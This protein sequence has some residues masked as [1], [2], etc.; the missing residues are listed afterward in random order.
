[1]AKAKKAKGKW[2][3][4]K[5]IVVVISAVILIAGATVGGVYLTGGFDERHINPESIA[6]VLDENLY[7]SEHEQFEVT[8][9]FSLTISTPT[10]DVTHKD[11]NLS[12][13]S[14]VSV[15]HD[16]I[17]KTLSDGII[18]VPETVQIGTPFTVK[19]NKKLTQMSGEQIVE[20]VTGGISKLRA[21]STANDQISA[22]E[23]QIAV[24]VPVHSIQVELFDAVSNSINEITS[25]E[26]FTAQTHFFPVGSNYFYS[27]DKNAA[28]EEK[29]EKLAYYTV[30][31]AGNI[32]FVYSDDGVSFEAGERLRDNNTSSI[33][34]YTFRSADKQT[35]V[36][37]NFS[38]YSGS[39]L[40]STVL[41]YLANN[42]ETVC[43]TN[44][45]SPT[46][47][48]V[49][50]ATIGY[51]R[52]EQAGFVFNLINNA[53]YRIT[54]N[55]DELADNYLGATIGGTTTGS[56]LKSMLKNIAIA[57]EEEIA[58]DTWR[59]ITTDKL[60]VNG[61]GSVEIDG[62]TYY[63]PNT[64][65]SD[66][67]SAYFDLTAKQTLNLRMT[68]VLLQTE[69]IDEAGYTVYSVYQPDKAT[70][71]ISVKSQERQEGEISWSKEDP[72]NI[73]LGYNGSEI[74][75]KTFIFGEGENAQGVV[76]AS[77][78][79]QSKVYFAYFG[80]NDEE[81]A[82]TI[83]NN[84][85]GEGGY[86]HQGLYNLG[87]TQP[88]YLFP[89]EGGELTVRATQNFQVFVAT[90]KTNRVGS[91]EVF[92]Y[93]TNGLYT[94][95]K[96]APQSLNVYVA[97]SLYQGSV[98][99]T[100]NA[101]VEGYNNQVMTDNYYL[102]AGSDRVTRI[103]LRFEINAD[104]ASV[105]AEKLVN[106][107]VL[108]L[109]N[110][111]GADIT[112]YFSIEYPT[113]LVEDNDG[114][115]ARFYADFTLTVRST[116]NVT[117]EVLLK[118]AKLTETGSKLEWERDVVT[119]T[120]DN[121]SKLIYIYMPTVQDITI[122][123]DT[124]DLTKTI[125]VSQEL[126]ATSGDFNTNIIYYT[127]ADTDTP[128]GTF[129]STEQLIQNL[130]VVVTD[131]HFNAFV[132]NDSW[133][134]ATTNSTVVTVGGK[135]FTFR[136]AD[137]ATADIYATCGQKD[138]ARIKFQVTS[139]GIIAVEYDNQKVIGG[140]S[141]WQRSAS[142]ASV[143][144]N[145]YASK[146]GSI[147][148]K[149]I[150]KLYT[151][152]D[153]DDQVDITSQFKKFVVKFDEVKLTQLGDLVVPLF[154]T[155]GMLTVYANEYN[156]ENQLIG[157]KAVEFAKNDAATI[158]STL[159]GKEIVSLA[160]KYDFANEDRELGFVISDASKSG[161][162]AISLSLNLLTNAATTNTQA[163]VEVY[164]S[165]GSEVVG[166]VIFN[167]NPDKR[168]SI[169][170][171]IE[172]F[173]GK[174]IATNGNQTNKNING[175]NV[176][177]NE[178]EIVDASTT[179]NVVGEIDENGKIVF[180]DFWDAETKYYRLILNLE[181]FSNRYALYLQPE[182]TVHRNI[183]VVYKSYS[184]EDVDN[185]VVTADKLGQQKT[186]K[187]LG[188]TNAIRDY[189]EIARIEG[190]QPFNFE[191]GILPSLEPVEDNPVLTLIG[192]GFN[193]GLAS[194]EGTISTNSQNIPF[195]NYHNKNQ[196]S[197][198]AFKLGGTTIDTIGL[199]YELGIE[200]E[201]VAVNLYRENA[202]TKEIT[203]R[204][205]TEKIGDRTYI[206][207]QRGTYKVNGKIST[208]P[209]GQSNIYDFDIYQ[210]ITMGGQYYSNTFYN[211]MPGAETGE[212]VV[213]FNTPQLSA[214]QGLTEADEKDIILIFSSNG[215]RQAV[216]IMPL[217][218][219][220]I[221][222]DFVNYVE[223]EEVSTDSE[224]RGTNIVNTHD[225]FNTLENALLEPSKLFEKGVYQEVRA[226]ERIKIASK[227][228]LGQVPSLDNIGFVTLDDEGAPR[229]T[230]SI[231]PTMVTPTEAIPSGQDR[232][233][234]PEL[235]KN[236]YD[237]ENGDIE[238]QLNH[239]SDTIQTAYVAIK[240]VVSNG[241]W[242]LPFYYLLKVTPNAKVNEPCY[243]FDS[244]AQKAGKENITGVVNEIIGGVSGINLN[245]PWGDA[246]LN[247]GKTRFSVTID[248]K[249][250]SN[251]PSV[252]RVV[253]V[254]VG[255]GDPLTTEEEYKDYIDV[256]LLNGVM[257]VTPKTTAAIRLIIKRVYNGGLG[258][259]QLSV[260]GGE[261]QYIFDI[262]ASAD[263]YLLYED[264]ATDKLS[265]V[266]VSPLNRNEAI[267]T[268]KSKA[269]TE[270]TI[271]VKLINNT[272]TLG[273]VGTEVPG[274]LSYAFFD[275]KMQPIENSAAGI[276]DSITYDNMTFDLKVTRSE[277]VS[278]DK[279]V[280]VLF[281]TEYGL[282]GQLNIIVEASAQA[283]YTQQ[284]KAVHSGNYNLSD[285]ARISI[286]EVEETDYTV[287]KA[288]QI[289]EEG[290]DAAQRLFVFDK[291][292][293]K[294]FKF[295]PAIRDEKVRIEIEIEFNDAEV[296]AVD[297]GTPVPAA[298]RT[299]A[300]TLELD[301]KKDIVQR[302]DTT[303]EVGTSEASAE[304]LS[305]EK[306]ASLLYAQDIKNLIT[307]DLMRFVHADKAISNETAAANFDGHILYTWTG[308]SGR[309]YIK[310]STDVLNRAINIET[311]NVGVDDTSVNVLI[312]AYLFKG[313]VGDNASY[314]SSILTDTNYG[315]YAT[316]MVQYS[317]TIQPNVK[318]VTTYPNPTKTTVEKDKLTAEYLKN[319]AM[320][321]W[322]TDLINHSPVFATEK[323]I[324]FVKQG[325]NENVKTDRYSVKVDELNNVTM[326]YRFANDPK[327]TW[328][329]TTEG[330]KS[331]LFDNTALSDEELST[332]K[333][334][335]KIYFRLGTR[336]SQ[337]EIIDNGNEGV[338]TLRIECNGVTGYYNIRIQDSVLTVNVNKTN[339][340]ENGVETIYVDSLIKDRASNILDQNRIINFKLN[341]SS[342]NNN[343]S[344]IIS[345][346][347]VLVFENKEVITNSYGTNGR[348]FY[349]LRK[350]T[351]NDI[352]KT[353]N[354]D[355]GTRLIGYD[356][357]GTYVNDRTNFAYDELNNIIGFATDE[358]DNL[359]ATI[360]PT[361]D[362]LLYS[363]KPNLT[364]RITL[365]YIAGER[366]I[367]V[368]YSLIDNGKFTYCSSVQGVSAPFT[369][370]SGYAI[371]SGADDMGTEII[372]GRRLV[373]DGSLTGSEGG[374]F[375]FNLNNGQASNVEQ[376]S[377][378]YIYRTDIDIDVRD[379]GVDAL[380]TLKVGQTVKLIEQNHVY[381][382]STGE[383][384]S[385]KDLSADNAPTIKLQIINIDKMLTDFGYGV[386]EKPD[387][388]GTKISDF[389]DKKKYGEY[390]HKPYGSE[391]IVY[392][393]I[394]LAP[395]QPNDK[396]LDVNITAM[397]AKNQNTYV[398]L[399][400]TY[401][402][403]VNGNDYTKDYFLIYKV[404]PDY[405]VQFAGTQQN[406]IDELDRPSNE[407]NPYLV[408]PSEGSTSVYSNIVIAGSTDNSVPNIVTVRHENSETGADVAAEIFT[409]TMTP[410]RDLN[411]EYNIW[412]NVKEKMSDALTDT[413]WTGFNANILETETPKN[414][415][416]KTSA[417][418]KICT[419]VGVKT[420]Y[421]GQQYYRL[422][423]KDVYGYEFIVYFTLDSGRPRPAV[424][425]AQFNIQENGNFDIGAQF[426]V[427]E[428]VLVNKKVDI[429]PTIQNGSSTTEFRMLN[430]TGLNAWGFDND[431][432]ENLVWHTAGYHTGETAA[433]F[434]AG[435]HY[436]FKGELEAAEP[437]ADSKYLESPD[438]TKVT[439]QEINF[440]DSK[441]QLI[442]NARIGD[443]KGTDL[444]TSESLYYGDGT[445]SNNEP[446]SL[447]KYRNPANNIYKMPQL[448]GAIYG[449]SSTANITTVI[450]LLY[451]GDNGNNEYF[452]VSVPTVVTRDVTFSPST[453]NVI[454][455]GDNFFINDYITVYTTSDTT[456]LTPNYYDDTLRITLPNRASVTFSLTRERDGEKISSSIVT[457]Q[458]IASYTLTETRSISAIMGETSQVGD[459][460]TINVISHSNA[461]LGIDETNDFRGF[462]LQYGNNI[463]YIKDEVDSSRDDYKIVGTNISDLT[464][465]TATAPLQDENGEDVKFTYVLANEGLSSMPDGKDQVNIVNA[466]Q[467]KDNRDGIGV[468]KFYIADLNG[469][470]YQVAQ[471]YRVTSY[472]QSMSTNAGADVKPVQ[473]YLTVKSLDSEQGTVI[474][475]RLGW[476]EGM[477]LD[478]G[479]YSYTGLNTIPYDSFTEN[480]NNKL[481]Y[482]I[483]SEDGSAGAA[484]IDE[485]GMVTTTDNFEISAQHFVVNVY[486]KA[487]GL[488]GR[489]DKKSEDDKLLGT[490]TFM[491]EPP[492]TN[493][494]VGG[495]PNQTIISV[496][497]ENGNKIVSKN[498]V[499]KAREYVVENTTINI[500]AAYKGQNVI[501]TISK[502]NLPQSME[503][504]EETY[505]VDGMNLGIVKS[506]IEQSFVLT[507]GQALYSQ[508][509]D[510]STK[511]QLGPVDGKP[512]R[513]IYVLNPD[514][515]GINVLDKYIKD[516]DSTGRVKTFTENKELTGADIN[517]D[518][519]LVYTDTKNNKMFF[520]LNS[521]ERK[522]KY[523][524]MQGRRLSEDR[525]IS[526]SAVNADGFVAYTDWMTGE[527]YYCR[528][529]E[530]AFT[531]EDGKY[532]EATCKTKTVLKSDTE[533]VYTCPV[534]GQVYSAEFDGYSFFALNS[535]L[536][537]AVGNLGYKVESGV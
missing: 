328:D 398:L 19:L 195:F 175:V 196:V 65:V 69:N 138:T 440:R 3:I 212:V 413:G 73:T 32:E 126:D 197:E 27:D 24:D 367:P 295:F 362:R 60:A 208:D 348:V 296:I 393:F 451:A 63:L 71:R 252:D 355:F 43:V 536:Y 339:E 6:F 465:A 118:S 194:W 93:D 83:A 231:V 283:E 341:S 324:D 200:P 152:V 491:L 480:A 141:D 199:K 517:E 502:V 76:P 404:E 108:S 505:L 104:S 166:D 206:I 190:N 429:Q 309:E 311:N 103:K 278:A 178:C 395:Y 213:S 383:M 431:P 97:K 403:T 247:R 180:K 486:I 22:I 351:T 176:A 242:E 447:V 258:D 156:S 135:S 330:G 234:Y 181:G 473:K 458:N 379:S 476:T 525:A 39:E 494:A 236:F 184:Q 132:F 78:L 107:I 279:K 444:S 373:N 222:L 400:F 511:Y 424:S 314:D 419:L 79:Y 185:K 441:G 54:M 533:I 377:T 416:W 385:S 157:T 503:V 36:L 123:S 237:L 113:R 370:L 129:A 343:I 527:R 230:L 116:I 406:D 439:V 174:K 270:R 498:V 467:I 290:N 86:L 182:Y 30:I 47:I 334:L 139:K 492:D 376:F 352:G 124:I 92:E 371:E 15:Q 239:L 85:L 396:I 344:N 281:Y 255:A 421:I 390:L 402:A 10:E 164:A 369:S 99:Q 338:V 62:V 163:S 277:Y 89:I 133:N 448:P 414:I 268:L 364:G 409:Y 105:F 158:R 487:A 537:S 512:G 445:N 432:P 28:V 528:F 101:S 418:S 98:S 361:E 471:G 80:T 275:E 229:Y 147:L 165:Q 110:N 516:K 460:I 422:F 326:F 261:V 423:A 5:T 227:N 240:A 497:A 151:N 223:K 534:A 319:G 16:F 466:R 420:V 482:K 56:I 518:G 88:Y 375:K 23:T 14:G 293:E 128:T 520:K 318:I 354:F 120:E 526:Y 485:S 496:V 8:G 189:F 221:G 519:Y 271:S 40:Y 382:P 193:T 130:S 75:P 349:E 391:N 207:A 289:I 405:I 483:S 245:E 53:P 380:Q 112:N 515:D 48:E 183:K 172:T 347:Y 82:T 50:E 168:T 535:R 450:T 100:L 11:V 41:S 372:L 13:P 358:F 468:S 216:A 96:A 430:I 202:E 38:Q 472:Y 438:F 288:E 74:D 437:K 44:A 241:S 459:K 42:D 72:I 12:F 67:D 478:I 90:V 484:T 259:D 145:K 461:L 454:R 302:L 232:I 106:D 312:T 305:A 148:L 149:D 226:G 417:N 524:E 457:V 188:V 187:V 173:H 481:Y 102:Y 49:V 249:T 84:V 299:Y 469:T 292:A 427:L 153:K 167:S 412:G 266:E 91:Q 455:D 143:T 115:G 150:V 443:K 357:V 140:T 154:G 294:Q 265:D 415:I 301:V 387:S 408:A 499:M 479:R 532:I 134:Y 204:A 300:F 513:D 161:A 58:A 316:F 214:I 386:N 1:M 453:N 425:E 250:I 490:V 317:F 55:H 111:D 446:V 378:T 18:T 304:R 303:K 285:F 248:G 77:N 2:A 489:F 325:T 336:N 433:L 280:V 260:V 228:I 501:S 493:G 307:T 210:S 521:E 191:D 366:Y 282:L 392:R 235:V 274:K 26:S 345:S 297:G 262:N 64:Q 463:L 475:P 269:T 442:E 500:S 401:T 109:H 94:I 61:R 399:Y 507:K 426:E 291:D 315:H 238:L 470:A 119:F 218:V 365:S 251:L 335:D 321:E 257:R 253:S 192:G 436:C 29:R 411:G 306:T 435:N 287:T 186:L 52:V 474:V 340:D 217:L 477:T 169:Q 225:V 59:P 329:I 20:W 529:V 389:T 514:Y 246:T 37:N 397:G 267:W 434:P 381:H 273:E 177:I 9:D 137:N 522:V 308:L 35:E 170:S 144:V 34:G 333:G 368:D 198:F 356:Y 456:N 320:F 464:I 127:K 51:F 327:G 201:K 21:A 122:S 68:V 298:K 256:Q 131:D 394:S 160:V 342:E 244:E 310:S 531:D 45:S 410:T 233:Y 323:R 264:K 33:V 346:P 263:Y 179:N 215:T 407:S 462:Y 322:A 359:S 4:W 509:N 272:V 224:T 452:D 243:A 360:H 136:T 313:N 506:D 428:D 7:N 523:V 388:T 121:V 162:V 331:T 220:N 449:A 510:T 495:Y 350:L 363:S 374:H 57:F 508:L 142:E 95:V 117:G 219:S 31:G 284:A 286:E 25:G 384:L 254:A 530:N 504:A 81:A 159:S 332:Y 211:L 171:I 155:N 70:Y 488:Y 46:E 353:L 203:S 276:I 205:K 337:G 125:E 87:G 66:L 209:T 17:A 146:G 114:N